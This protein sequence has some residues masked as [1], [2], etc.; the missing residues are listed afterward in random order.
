MTF[1]LSI[2]GSHFL[3]EYLARLRDACLAP[4]EVLVRELESGD[5][6]P[7]P[8]GC[9]TPILDKRK[10]LTNQPRVSPGGS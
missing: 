7:L 1:T 10:A 6:F 5:P 8:L 9:A 3:S 2:T 4:L